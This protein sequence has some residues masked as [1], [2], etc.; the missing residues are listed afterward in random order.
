MMVFYNDTQMFGNYS[1]MS[2]AQ[3]VG[4]K[5]L[6]NPVNLLM[7]KLMLDHM[8]RKNTPLNLSSIDKLDRFLGYNTV[9]CAL[10]K[11]AKIVQSKPDSIDTTNGSIV[12]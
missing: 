2:G 7:C 1:Y 8:D 10:A 9:H 12:G 6:M 5:V 3:L 11:N 4:A